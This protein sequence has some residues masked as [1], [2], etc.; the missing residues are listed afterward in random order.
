[1]IFQGFYLIILPF[2]TRYI[3]A[4]SKYKYFYFRFYDLQS[5]YRPKSRCLI[6]GGRF[7]SWVKSELLTLQGVRKNLIYNI[8]KFLLFCSIIAQGLSFSCSHLSYLHSNP[9]KRGKSKQRTNSF[10]FKG[11]DQKVRYITSAHILIS[12]L[13]VTLICMGVWKIP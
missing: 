11:C 2:L 4:F 5:S 1:M 8:I 12:T 6:G 3:Y 13:M 9:L 7:C 10:F